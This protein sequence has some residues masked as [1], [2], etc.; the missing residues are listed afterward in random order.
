MVGEIGPEYR[1]L[2]APDAATPIEKYVSVSDPPVAA[3][4]LIADTGEVD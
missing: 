3:G 1:I 4:K 2:D